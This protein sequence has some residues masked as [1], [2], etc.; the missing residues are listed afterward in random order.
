MIGHY[1]FGELEGEGKITFENGEGLEVNF[2]KGYIHG[3]AR[4][5]D[6]CG[7]IVRIVEYFF[8]ESRGIA[9]E[10]LA[11]GGALTGNLGISS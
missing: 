6:I 7:N 10:F 3:L 8:G 9:W 1:E 11:G 4:K 5:T 2:H